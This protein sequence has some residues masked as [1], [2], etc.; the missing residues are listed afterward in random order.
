M[1]APRSVPLIALVASAST[2]TGCS[3]LFKSGV[4]GSFTETGRPLVGYV[5]SRNEK[6]R[7]TLNLGSAE[8]QECKGRYEV[9]QAGTSVL[10]LS[11]KDQ[12]YKGQIYCLDGRVGHFEL[13][14]AKKG[15]TGSIAGEIGGKTFRAD[16]IEQSGNE[17]ENDECRRGVKWTYESERRDLH[18]YIK[19]EVE[20]KARLGTPVTSDAIFSAYLM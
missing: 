17:C 13:V 11:I 20:H 6:E 7:G 14:S 9:S 15:R 10:G 18:T 16:L 2:L 19:V 1:L 8:K 12:V 3:Y 5:M 4:E